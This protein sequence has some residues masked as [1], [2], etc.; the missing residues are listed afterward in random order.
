MII[1]SSEEEMKGDFHSQRSCDVFLSSFFSLFFS[2]CIVIS[3]SHYFPQTCADQSWR[4]DGSGRCA[5]DN[6]AASEQNL[7][8]FHKLDVTVR[9]SPLQLLYEDTAGAL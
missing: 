4:L 3:I 2:Q 6:T 8:E 1:N 7:V 5:P 9:K